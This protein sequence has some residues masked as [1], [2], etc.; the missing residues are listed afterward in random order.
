[1]L[2]RCTAKNFAIISH[3]NINGNRRNLFK[4]KFAD[5]LRP[6]K[7]FFTN[8]K[9]DVFS[10]GDNIVIQDNDIQLITKRMYHLVLFL[11]VQTTLRKKMQS[12]LK[13]NRI[14]NTNHFISLLGNVT[15]IL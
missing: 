15:L 12:F 3:T 14:N 8:T 9:F 4:Y 5:N 1:M 2:E 7:D 11:Q 13:D 6:K 10:Q